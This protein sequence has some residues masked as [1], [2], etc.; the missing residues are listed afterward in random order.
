LG[1]VPVPRNIFGQGSCPQKHFRAKFL[2]PETL[3]GKQSGSGDQQFWDAEPA[4][5]PLS[6]NRF[7]GKCFVVQEYLPSNVPDFQSIFVMRSRPRM[8]P[9]TNCQNTCLVPV[10]SPCPR[11]QGY[12]SLIFCSL[13][14]M[15]NTNPDMR[16][17]DTVGLARSLERSRKGPGNHDKSYSVDS[18]NH[19][20]GENIFVM[21]SRRRIDLLTNYQ[22]TG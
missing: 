16:L 18:G 6:H 10:H 17:F 22:K 5:Q 1:N 7:S 19:I 9:L 4:E 13:H 11:H 15:Q 12:V 3:S 8:D 2:S 14:K 20:P 21:Q